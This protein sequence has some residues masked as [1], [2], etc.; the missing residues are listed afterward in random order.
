MRKVR[1]KNIDKGEGL[2]TFVVDPRKPQLTK[3]QLAEALFGMTLE[4]L[5]RDI[6]ENKDGKWDEAYQKST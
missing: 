1:Q 6:R 5:V 3:E 4:E 2:G